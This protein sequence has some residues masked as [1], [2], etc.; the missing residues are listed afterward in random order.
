MNDDII[1]TK[2][3]LIEMSKIVKENESDLLKKFNKTEILDVIDL[4]WM[5]LDCCD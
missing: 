1:I 4:A 3:R 2:D 5:Y